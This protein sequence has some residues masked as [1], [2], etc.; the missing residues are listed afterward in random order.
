MSDTLFGAI[1]AR[2]FT[3]FGVLLA[4][5]LSFFRKLGKLSIYVTWEGVPTSNNPNNAIINYELLGHC[6]IST[7]QKDTTEY[8]Y[9]L[10][11]DIY[12]NS[13]YAK[14]M[15][16]IVIEF[17]D[18]NNVVFSQI[19]NDSKN[20]KSYSS[21]QIHGKVCALN[22]PPKTILQYKYFERIND[23]DLS[24]IWQCTNVKLS[25]I[26]EKGKIKSVDIAE[27][28]HDSYFRKQPKN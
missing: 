23:N 8:K 15:R 12:N 19:P 24:I 18:K 3:L 5:L 21:G 16:S 17:M 27:L 4:S 7:S 22:I 1:I 25:Y 14:I 9:A 10:L 13:S 2:S 26:N 20:T 6:R 28:D 11:L